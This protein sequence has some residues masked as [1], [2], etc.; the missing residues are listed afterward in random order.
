MTLRDMAIEVLKSKNK[1][2]SAK[3]I[4]SIAK[5]KGLTDKLNVK[6]KNPF[7]TFTSILYTDNKRRD[8]TFVIHK[9]KPKKFTLFGD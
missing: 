9:T 8:K 5:Q 3:E 1:P 2:L 6:S 4:W 7:T